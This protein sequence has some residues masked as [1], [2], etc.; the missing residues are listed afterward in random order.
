MQ[1]ARAGSS[2]TALV[3]GD[4]T[5]A[6]SLVR[7]IVQAVAAVEND[8]IERLPP[9]TS[10]VDPD[11]LT[12]LFAHGETVGHVSFRYHGHRIVVMSSGDVSVY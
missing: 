11:A 4:A 3:T 7:C 6:E 10:V 5:D 12:D 9:L 8:E 1:S 2:E